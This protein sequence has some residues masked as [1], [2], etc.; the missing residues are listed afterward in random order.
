M[1]WGNIKEILDRDKSCT[2]SSRLNNVTMLI[3]SQLVSRFNVIPIKS[4]KTFGKLTCVSSNSCDN[5]KDL[6]WSNNS[7]K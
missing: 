5:V 7:K 6:Q 4:Q 3:L 1:I 2:L